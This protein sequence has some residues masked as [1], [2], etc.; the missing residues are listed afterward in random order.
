MK[1]LL[2]LFLFFCIWRVFCNW[3]MARSCL[4]LD[5]EL[6]ELFSVLVCS[7]YWCV[8]VCEDM[9]MC[10]CLPLIFILLWLLFTFWI[11]CFISFI[12]FWNSLAITDANI[13]FS[14]FYLHFQFHVCYLTTW[15]SVL[16]ASHPFL[17]F[18][19]QIGSLY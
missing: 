8:H 7:F 5:F 19:F 13:S 18:M 16:P 10:V 9:W 11:H 6:S 14:L 12:I 15:S 4:Q 2:L 1:N 3:L 17:F